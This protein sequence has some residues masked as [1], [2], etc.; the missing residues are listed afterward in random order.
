VLQAIWQVGLE[1]YANRKIGELSGGQQQRAFI[2]RA[3]VSRPEILILDE[4]TVGV[5]AQNVRSFYRILASL[6]KEMGM[7]LLMVSHDIEALLNEATH[8]AYINRKVHFFGEVSEYKKFRERNLFSMQALLDD[9][10]GKV[11]VGG[12]VRDSSI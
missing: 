12:A 8:V 7:T 4:P 5:D 6:R 10:A 2:A 1:T 11:G 3:I 9:A